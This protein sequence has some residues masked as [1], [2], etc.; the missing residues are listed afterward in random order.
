MV[1]V[2]GNG[3]FLEGESLGLSIVT[4]G[5]VYMRG[6]EVALPKSVTFGV[7][8]QVLPGCGT[9]WHKSWTSQII[10]DGWQPTEA[11][12]AQSIGAQRAEAGVGFL[13]GA[14]SPWCSLPS[15]RGSGE[16]CK[17]PAGSGAEPQPKSNLVHF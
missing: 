11:P 8:G 6:G 16:H 2:E 10:W 15:A 7:P 12:K 3:Q 5:I 9:S 17:L 4:N 1:I 13:G 14:A